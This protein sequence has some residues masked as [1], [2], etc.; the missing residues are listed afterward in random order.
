[1]RDLLLLLLLAGVAVGRRTL[2]HQAVVSSTPSWVAVM[3]LLLG[4]ATVCGQV[5]HRGIQ[6]TTQVNS[7]TVHRG[8][9][10]VY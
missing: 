7:A 6:P 8:Y 5:N 4:W 10:G 2:L 9:S 1:M 3:C